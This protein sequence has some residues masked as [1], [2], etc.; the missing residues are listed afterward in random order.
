MMTNATTCREA[1]RST[2]APPVGRDSPAT[3]ARGFSAPYHK[4]TL[5]KMTLARSNR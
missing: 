2:G 4:Q 3:A 5:F 1:R